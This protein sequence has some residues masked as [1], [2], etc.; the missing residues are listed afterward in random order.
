M[1]SLARRKL[2][3][4]L[5][6]LNKCNQQIILLTCGDLSQLSTESSHNGDSIVMNS[7]NNFRSKLSQRRK[8]HPILLNHKD[9]TGNTLMTDSKSLISYKFNFVN[10]GNDEKVACQESKITSNYMRLRTGSESI[11]PNLRKF[12]EDNFI[13]LNETENRITPK[14]SSKNSE[15]IARSL[16][17]SPI[18]IN[19]ESVFDFDI[20]INDKILF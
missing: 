7:I 6:C 4:P 3:K 18:K 17:N 11:L 15:V 14:T 9:S 20:N 10:S 8:N 16:P 1:D 2:T 12:W 5:S 13:D 19:T